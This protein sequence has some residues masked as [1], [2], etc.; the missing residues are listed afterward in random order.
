MK[1][2]VKE[3]LLKNKE[4]IIC[5]V[6]NEKQNEKSDKKKKED[7]EEK[8]KRE[9]IAQI[10]LLLM[11]IIYILLGMILLGS[12]KWFVENP[13]N[14]VLGYEVIIL[15]IY[16]LLHVFI[17][18][19]EQTKKREK[20]IIKNIKEILIFFMLPYHLCIK[21]IKSFIK[22]RRQEHVS[23][24][25]P[26]YLMSLFVVMFTYIFMIKFVANRGIDKVYNECI[27]FVVVFCLVKEFLLCGKWFA[28]LSTKSV[29]KSIQKAQLKRTTKVNWRGAMKDELHKQE[30]CKKF[31]E[32]WIVVKEELE[33][34]E[35][36]FYIFLTILVMCIPK[37]SGSLSELL[38]NQFLGITTVAALARE[39][40]SK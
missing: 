1:N 23:Q 8:I 18:F 15:G 21:G 37:E 17:F 36:Y 3:W 20:W 2:K 30:R 28:Y 31:E 29:I 10:F 25:F 16:A 11:G 24:F 35:I 6:I 33:Y 32:E 26:Y 27:G 12:S 7:K 40:K 5:S 4:E 22:A 38:S 39:A 9:R 34:T 19:C 14:T 13:Q